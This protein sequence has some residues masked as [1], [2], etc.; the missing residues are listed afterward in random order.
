MPP[1]QEDNSSDILIDATMETNE[2]LGDIA[3]SNEVQ[4]QGIMETNEELNE[5]NRTA[6]MI[7][8]K[9]AESR[10]SLDISINGAERVEIQGPKGEQGDKPLKGKDYFTPQEV[11]EI[12]SR[13]R[14]SVRVPKDGITPVRGKDYY[15]DEDIESIITEVVSRIP[16]PKDGED[17]VVDYEYVLSETLKRLPKLRNGKDGRDGRNGSPDTPEQVK[18]KLM[19]VGISYEEIK[20][21][22]VFKGASKTVSLTELDDVDYS[23]LSI[24]DGKYVLG[25][26]GSGGTWGSITGTLSAQTDLQSALDAKG[27]FTL[28]ALTSGSVLF[29]D[30]STIAQD[31]ANLFW[32]NANNRLGIGT[33]SPSVLLDVFG[34]SNIVSIGQNSGTNDA[35]VNQLTIRTRSYVGNKTIRNIDRGSND[36]FYVTD[37]GKVALGTYGALSAGYSLGVSNGAVDITGNQAGFQI[38]DRTTTTDKWQHYSTG[39]IFRIYRL[40]SAVAS[41]PFN[42]TASTGNIGMGLPTSTSASARLHLISTTE[43]FRSGYDASNY[44]NA[45]TSSA[46]VTTFDAVGASASFIFSDN[47]QAPYIGVGAAANLSTG[48]LVAGTGYTSNLIAATGSLSPTAGT[49]ATLYRIAGTIV[50]AASGTHNLMS[51]MF[52]GTTTVTGGAATVNNTAGL[53]IEGPMTATV[54]GKNYSAW[55]D[56]GISRFD[57]A[58]EHGYVAK[59]AAYTLTDSDYTVN[60]TSGT[61]AFTLPTAVGI[62]GRVY[63]IKNSGT[64]TI[65]INTTSSQTVDGNA[66]GAISLAQYDSYT[67]Q[68][69]GANWIII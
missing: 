68:S 53:Y 41:E 64:G 6:D 54:S 14:R 62:T 17:A 47:I 56:D 59:T 37:Q 46:G 65:T 69:D 55:I 5:L 61:F 23:G 2:K 44:W 4:V 26:G 50:E 29:S 12:I 33:T 1:Q 8:E 45:T 27:T 39:G 24:A 9:V 21:A 49:N 18:S 52:L 3:D 66:S 10:T 11:A 34:A 30:G 31:N 38:S 42:I 13:V 20:G 43:Q 67:V 22:P 36:N 7:L 15:T 40:L 48:L 58:F 57:G 32:D 51:A 63:V 25:S 60:A 35:D 28:P 16:M 19:E